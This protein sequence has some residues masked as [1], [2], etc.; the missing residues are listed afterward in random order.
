MYINMRYFQCIG[1]IDFFKL[2]MNK[3]ELILKL[4]DKD[5]F[6]EGDEYDLSILAKIIKEI[7]DTENK[8]KEIIFRKEEEYPHT[9]RYFVMPNP[10]YCDFDIYVIAK[11][12]NNGSTYVFAPNEK[13]LEEMSD[14]YS[15]IERI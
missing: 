14:S 12:S 5:E 8:V 15:L 4:M 7:E 2:A 10:D 13:Y 6:L 3:K 1:I 11:V 9:I